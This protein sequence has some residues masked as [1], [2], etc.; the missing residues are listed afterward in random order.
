MIDPTEETDFDELDLEAES[1]AM[2]AQELY[3]ELV[4]KDELL[5]TVENHLV[6]D[7]KAALISTKA[8]EN[9][10]LKAKGMP[11]DNAKLVVNTVK[12][13]SLADGFTKMHLM[14]VKRKTFTI[15]K[16]ESPSNEL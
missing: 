10:K 4:L 9:S 13:A 15:A 6:E 8:K 12:D 14:L 5:L 16:I 2:T 7:I 3:C 1:E 11:V